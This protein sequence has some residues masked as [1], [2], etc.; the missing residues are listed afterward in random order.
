MSDKTDHMAEFMRHALGGDPPWWAEAVASHLYH[1]AS[2]G[3]QLRVFA[4]RGEIRGPRRILIQHPNGRI[5]LAQPT[6]P[7]P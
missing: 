5:M 4:T 7:T 3:E 2:E 1:A 6:E